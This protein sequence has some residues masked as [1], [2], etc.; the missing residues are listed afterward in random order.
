MQ[1]TNAICLGGPLEMH[2][3]Q[4]VTVSLPLEENEL[5]ENKVYDYYIFLIPR[6]QPS[7]TLIMNTPNTASKECLMHSLSLSLLRL[8]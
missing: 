3:S 1:T 7:T 2:K 8:E 6:R 5:I 4:G